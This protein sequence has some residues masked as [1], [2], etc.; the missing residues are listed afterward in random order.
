[1]APGADDAA[2]PRPYR[3]ADEPA[4]GRWRA[5]AVDPNWPL[6]GLMLAGAWLGWPW[7][8]VNARALGSPTRRRELAWVLAGLVGSLVLGVLLLELLALGVLRGPVPLQL[9]LL[10]IA[11]WKLIAA[12]A[13]H[14]LQGRPLPRCGGEGGEAQSGLGVLLVAVFVGRAIVLSLVDD[15]LWAL[16]VGGVF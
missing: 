10:A 16:L 3:L 8:L 5:I 6:V 9:G 15:P 4:L 7:F 12:A 2:L 14:G 11:T 1:M 13:V